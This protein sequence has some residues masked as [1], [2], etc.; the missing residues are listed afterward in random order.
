M[1]WIL[2]HQNWQIYPLSIKHRCFEYHYT[3]P[4]RS[5]PIN[6]ASDAWILLL[7]NL[8]GLLADLPPSMKNRCLEYWYTNL[9]DLP[10]VQLSI[11]A[12]NTTTLKLADLT[13]SIAHRCLNTAT[14]NLTDLPPSIEHSCLWILLHQTWQI[15]PYSIKCRC[16]EHH[17][18][19]LGRSTGRSTPF[20]GA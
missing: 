7:P 17:Y 15:Y 20:N 9:A 13:P 11:D 18:T 2:L 16:L 1:P 8:A 14:P 6:G 5:T 3:K 4:G 10:P 12:L 19:K